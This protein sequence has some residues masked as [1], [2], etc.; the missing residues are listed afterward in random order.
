MSYILQTPVSLGM[1]APQTPGSV[2]LYDASG[3]AIAYAP[4]TAG[5][6]LTANGAGT[7]PTWQAA[8][9]NSGTVAGRLMVPVLIERKVLAASGTFAT[10]VWTA[11]AYRRIFVD[12]KGSLSAGNYISMLANADGTAAY[13]NQFY[14][15]NGAG[16][17]LGVVA[18]VGFTVLRMGVTTIAGQGF[19]FHIEFDPRTD[20]LA[21]V[22]H[23]RSGSLHPSILANSYGTFSDSSWN[24]TATDWTFC[25]FG[26]FGI[27]AS[28]MTGELV[29][30]GIPA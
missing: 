10:A 17:P 20:G 19:S 1:M 27:G 18:D 2:L 14:L 28:T 30:T 15:S 7:P 25:T 5:Q 4:G 23:S 26:Q 6:V 11:G 21:R 16:S 12:F 24:N 3:N 22:V 29:V 9:V 13:S 8:Y